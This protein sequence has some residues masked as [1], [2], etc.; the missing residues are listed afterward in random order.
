MR[1][2]LNVFERSKYEFECSIATVLFGLP[3][4]YVLLPPKA[5]GT[6]RFEPTFDSENYAAAR[7]AA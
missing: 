2:W 3:L 5:R 1:K 6:G 4:V 7:V